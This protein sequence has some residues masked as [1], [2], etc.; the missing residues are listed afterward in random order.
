ML[1]IP[2]DGMTQAALNVIRQ[3][4]AFANPDFYRA[5]AMRQPIYDKPRIIY[6][7]EETDDIILLPRGCKESLTSLLSRT[8][9]VVS[10][11]NEH[12]PDE[13]IQ[14]EF[15]GTLLER[16]NVA[17]QNLLA[18]LTASSSLQQDSVKP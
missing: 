9:T 2:K 10:Y 5:Q 17:A 15:T 1:V 4:A 13:R 8:G 16:Q 18:L 12:N 3:L 11:R 7:G 6:R 14:V